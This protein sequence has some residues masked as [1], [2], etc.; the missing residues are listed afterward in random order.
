MLTG[1][2]PNKTVAVGRLVTVSAVGGVLAAALVLP[3][4]G[5]TGILTRNA[6][7]KFDSL[8]TQALGQLPQRSEILD[9]NGH[10]L[11][12]YSTIDRVPVNYDKIAPVMTDAI[13]GIEDSRYWEHGAIDIKGTFRAVVNNL[14]HQAVQ[15]GSTIAQQY[16]KNALILSAPDPQQAAAATT[17][18]LTRKLK[19]LRMAIQVEHQMSKEQLLA[20]YLNAAYFGNQA[21]GI[22][23]AAE[24]YFHTTAAKLSLRQAAMLAGMVENPTAYDPITNSPAALERRNTVLARM[25]QLG[26]VTQKAAQ[27]TESQSLGL[28]RHV[29]PLQ[30]GCMSSSAS[31]A[32]Y[33][34][35]YVLA[36]MQHDKAYRSAWAQLNGIGG[37]KIHTTLDRTDQRAANN[38]VYREMPYKDNTYNPGQNND[39][40]V[41]LQPGTGQVRAIAINVP[42]GQNTL[43]Y[44]VGPQYNGSREGVQIGST[45]KVYTM[46]AALEQGVPFGSSMKV[47]QSTTVTGYTNCQDQPTGQVVNSAG[48]LGWQVHNDESEPG[49]TFTLYTGT[50]ESI[51]TYYAELE[52]KVGLCKV[53]KT[54]AQ[55]GLTWPDGKS[56]LT[57]DRAGHHPQSAD[58][59][60]SFTLGDIGVT[61]IDVAASDAT[62]PARGVYCHPIAIDKI[63]N[64]SGKQLPVE[65]AG[66]HQVLPAAV[67]DAANYI[68]K[69]DLINGTA[70]NGIENDSIGRPA[71]S[72]T[73]TAD[74]YWYAAFVG[75][76]PGLIGVD[77]VGNLT[78]PTGNPMQGSNSCYHNVTAGVLTCAGWMYGSM[79]PGQTWQQTFLHASLTGAYDFAAVPANSPFNSMG[80]G[81]TVSKPKK[82]TGNGNGGNGNGRGNG[83]PPNCPTS[84]ICF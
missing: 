63:S 23:V 31:Y 33:F 36:V 55:M 43:D 77:V 5:A 82:T 13:V 73:G 27:K 41:L 44:A 61:P 78:N 9:R 42:Y 3:A 48:T 79:A 6:A 50:T 81:L 30:T 75:Y 10:V 18:T 20:A 15:G 21:Y 58:N 22:E 16:V 39:V 53:V 66:C 35:D 80:N 51:N 1:V 76:T 34:C 7:L 29:A 70:N 38:A 60:V 25:A 68:L 49:G 32:G 19:E 72:K 40:E 84:P 8:S 28:A 52:K 64:A 12:Y 4:V 62:L 45:G 54:A 17:D 47:P 2:R 83:N 69:G 11:A 67:A 57:P 65:S 26:L 14:Q 24:T 74:Q 71:A 59:V 37:L 56:L 46:V